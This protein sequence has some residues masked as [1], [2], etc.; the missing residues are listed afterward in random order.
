MAQYRCSIRDAISRGKGQ[1]A[2]AKAAYNAREKLRDER[3]GE[4]KDY[5]RGKDDIL[6]SGIFVDPKRNAPELTK[7]RAALWNAAVAAEK[8][9]DAREAQEIIVNL[10]H[11][12]TDQQRRFM[13]IDFVREQITR[14]T[15][16]VADVNIHRPPEHG[17]D[18]NYHAH[19]LMTV[20]E[21]GPDG[22]TG[23]RLE[24]TPEQIQHWKEKWAER[25]AKELRKAGFEI[26]ADRWLVG[27][28]SLEQQR[29]AARE[30]GDLAHAETLNHE[31]T[32]HR[33]PAASAMER[34]GQET[35]R[36]N[37]DRD[38]FTAAQETA[39]L[40]AELA[41]IE[42]EIEETIISMEADRATVRQALKNE[43]AEVDK[44]LYGIPTVHD[45]KR[46]LAE[47][48][49]LLA[50]HAE[51][52]KPTEPGTQPPPQQEKTA[53]SGFRPPQ[54]APEHLRGT[55]AQIWT[56]IHSSDNA[57][58]FAAALHDQGLALAAVTKEEAERSQ[59]AAAFAKELD[60]FAPA[61]RENE[62]L[63]VNER[64]YVYRLSERTTGSAFGDTQRYL[65]TLDRS[66]LQGVEATKQKQRQHFNENNKPTRSVNAPELRGT[67]AEIRIAYSL[68]ATG[69]EFANALEDRGLILAAVNRD[70]IEREKVRTDTTE[71]WKELRE[72]E[73][74]V[75]NQSGHLYRLTERNTG[76]SRK[77][78]A[79]RLKDIDRASLLNVKDARAVMDDLKQHRLDERAEHFEAERRERPLRGSAIDIRFAYR[80]TADPRAFVASLAERGIFLAV[81]TK[82]E[83]EESHKQAEAAR[84]EGRSPNATGFKE[85]ETV[86]VDQWGHV[87]RLSERITGSSFGDMQRYLRTLDREKISGIEDARDYMRSRADD[88]DRSRKDRNRTANRLL[89]ISNIFD[90]GD[91]ED[92]NLKHTILDRAERRTIENER[93]AERP[94]N[95]RDR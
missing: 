82:A 71:K 46:T 22:F 48:D 23:P 69:Q 76:E 75:I 52:A 86:A 31:A 61:Y 3:T 87:Y 27:H 30:R 65:R 34:K 36:G 5:S 10:P 4:I 45:M 89:G 57:K 83:A 64:G 49:Q 35:D 2:V 1:S 29:Q 90:A 55:P 81:P 25:G 68:T 51:R 11:E 77:A 12:L 20:R 85:H 63:A 79:E 84:A 33:G 17:D 94:R 70:D 7:G 72:G 60:R 9:K 39:K 66:T 13:L 92:R 40:T 78:V 19:I 67:A 28:L 44:L 37:I 47:V 32:K 59:R 15:G 6:F 21:I 53:A 95:T 88:E 43:L 42:K 56:A 54:A 91:S 18:R 14:N 93:A 38:K 80:T 41:Q 26:E 73:L 74:V 8:R 62:I 58:A 50:E 24:V 16:R